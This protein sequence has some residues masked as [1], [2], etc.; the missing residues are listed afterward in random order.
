MQGQ[1][2]VA[3]T[4][5]STHAPQQRPPALTITRLCR[6]P[7]RHQPSESSYGEGNGKLSNPSTCLM[8]ANLRS[9]CSTAARARAPHPARESAVPSASALAESF[10]ALSCSPATPPQQDV[11]NRLKL[12][13]VQV[14]RSIAVSA[15]PV[16]IQRKSEFPS[17][18]P[19]TL[20]PTP[21]TLHPTP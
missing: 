14:L 19:E 8:T 5:I 7:T 4:H 18:T 15:V 1:G 21:Y 2:H 13:A 16:S 11:A 6:V 12:V 3:S 20:H 17:G 9:R 10:T